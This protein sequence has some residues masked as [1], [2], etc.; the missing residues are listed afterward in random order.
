M[1]PFSF[2]SF[3]E[4]H[5]MGDHGE[6]LRTLQNTLANQKQDIINLK[7]QLEAKDV[8]LHHLQKE[9]QDAHTSDALNPE[10]FNQSH[11][12]DYFHY[13]TGFSYEQFKSLCQF[14]TFQLIQVHHKHTFLSHTN[15]SIMTSNNFHCIL[16][17]Y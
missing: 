7:L 14:L 1:F 11:V 9:L 5:D 3:T 4:E 6:E 8:Q 2:L 12:P 10:I 15:M 17:C 16:S 13:C